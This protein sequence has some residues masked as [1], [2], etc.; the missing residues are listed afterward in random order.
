MAVKP[1]PEGYHTVTPYIL[2]D[3]ASKFIGFLKQAF[4]ATEK[5]CMKLPDGKVSHAE[6]W[7]EDSAVMVADPRPGAETSTGSFYLYVPDTD[8]VYQKALQAGATSTLE[9]M[10]QFYGDRNAGVK[11]PFGNTWWIATHIEDVTPEEIEK[12]AAA[13]KGSYKDKK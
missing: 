11:D 8:M 5:L 13:L 3:G 12:R 9:P 4:N 10:D 6:L 1:I 2:V 7:I